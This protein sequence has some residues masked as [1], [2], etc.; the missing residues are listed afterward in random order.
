M[1]IAII[2]GPNLN[3]LGRRDPTIYGPETL[4]DTLDALRREFPEVNITDFQSNSEGE[5]ID[6][7]QSA[8]R[9]PDICGIVINPG[10]YAHYSY[11]IADAVADSRVPVVEVHISNI[12]SRENFRAVSVTA[13]AARAVITGCG[14]RGYAMAVDFLVNTPAC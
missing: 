5:I 9:L 2:N 14:R 13:R 12:Y 3:M 1:T 10:A 6:T 7:I 11:A 8:N 4:E